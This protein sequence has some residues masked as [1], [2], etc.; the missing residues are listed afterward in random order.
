MGGPASKKPELIPLEFDVEFWVPL[1]VGVVA[2]GYVPLVWF[3]VELFTGVIVLLVV[4]VEFVVLVVPLVVVV[5]LVITVWLVEL[6]DVVVVLL[7]TIVELV[8]VP[9]V[10]ELLV[11]PRTIARVAAKTKS[12][13][14]YLIIDNNL[15]F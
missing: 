9:F 12:N 11:W 6:P 15:I 1:P 5:L 3:V 8:W 4:V 13:R 7:S 10:V 2:L 14:A